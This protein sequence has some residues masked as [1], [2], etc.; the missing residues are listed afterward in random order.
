MYFFFRMY[1]F[2]RERERKMREKT[3]RANSLHVKNIFFVYFENE[4][5]YLYWKNP[6]NGLRLFESLNILLKDRRNYRENS[7][8]EFRWIAMLHNRIRKISWVHWMF[9]RKYLKTVENLRFLMLVK[10]QTISTN[11]YQ[12]HK[13]NVG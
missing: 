5:N 10:T 12:R 9:P 1:F 8:P 2:E 7:C 6:L 13:I 4:F 11:I 3:R